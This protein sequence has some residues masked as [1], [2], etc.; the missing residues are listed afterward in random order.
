MLDW[1]VQQRGA[2]P[3]SPKLERRFVDDAAGWCLVATEDI[4]GD[5]VVLSVPLTA[6]IT[7]EGADESL[8]SAHMARQLLQ[9]Q[10]QAQVADDGEFGI[11]PWLSVLP[12]HVDLPWLYW[13]AEQLEEL[14]DEDTLADAAH[15]RSLYDAACQVC[16]VRVGGRGGA[17][18]LR[19]CCWRD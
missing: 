7:S 5:E 13:S 17:Q 15:L 1:L 10:Q 9:Q 19:P 2:T 4:E 8:W 14:Q 3:S 12:R 16:T 11:A 18:A 6:A